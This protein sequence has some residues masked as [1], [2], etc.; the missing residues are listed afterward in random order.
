MVELP[1]VELPKVNPTQV[2]EDMGRPVRN[3]AKYLS[4]NFRLRQVIDLNLQPGLYLR[5]SHAAF[6]HAKLA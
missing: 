1:K 5:F 4:S 2:Y 6:S 3:L